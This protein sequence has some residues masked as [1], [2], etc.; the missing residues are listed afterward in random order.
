M[1]KKVYCTAQFQPKPGQE[2]R[3]FETLQSLEPNTLREDGCLQYVVTRRLT[4]PFADGE[5][6]PIVFHEIWADIESFEAHCQ[7]SEIQAFFQNC[8]LAEDGLA[9]DWN[10]CAYSDEPADYDHP[11]KQSDS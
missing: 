3:L 2:K 8:C 11:F 5:S 1:S 4:T 7:R 6:F 9:A 10:V